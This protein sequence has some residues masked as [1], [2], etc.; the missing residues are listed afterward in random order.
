MKRN[1]L[2]DYILH[3]KLMESIDWEKRTLPFDAET[4]ITLTGKL[5]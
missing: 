3:F 5:I 4:I 1:H 2:I